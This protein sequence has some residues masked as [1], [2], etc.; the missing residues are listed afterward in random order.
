MKNYYNLFKSNFFIAIALFSIGSTYSFSSLAQVQEMAVR[1]DLG[2][3]EE[4]SFTMRVEVNPPSINVT[5]HDSIDFHG[6][7]VVNAQHEVHNLLNIILLGLY[8]EHIPAGTTKR[9]PL[10]LN[11]YKERHIFFV[12]VKDQNTKDR[13]FERFIVK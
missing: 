6:K 5:A 12:V 10:Q 11:L 8:D 1:N 7:V 3:Q 2:K 9:Y 13:V 4:P